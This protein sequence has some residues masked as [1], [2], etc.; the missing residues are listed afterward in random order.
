MFVFLHPDGCFDYLGPLFGDEMEDEVVSMAHGLPRWPKGT[1]GQGHVG[2]KARGGI[3]EGRLGH[4]ET[5]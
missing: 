3:E 5:Q 4:V 1:T 2:S